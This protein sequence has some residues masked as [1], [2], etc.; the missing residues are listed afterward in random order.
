M[1]VACGSADL[2]GPWL[3]ARLSGFRPLGLG[4]WVLGLGFRGFLRRNGGGDLKGRTIVHV[5]GDPFP[6]PPLPHSLRSV[7]SAIQAVSFG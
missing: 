3:T 1:A 2:P 6:P 4:F 7:R 5:H